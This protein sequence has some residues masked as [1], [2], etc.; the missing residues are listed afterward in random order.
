MIVADGIEIYLKPAGDEGDYLKFP[1]LELPPNNN[2]EG[3]SKN[4]FIPYSDKP[5]QIV[6]KYPDNFD[7]PSASAVH[8]GCIGMDASNWRNY[9]KEREHEPVF[10]VNS[11]VS[12]TLRSYSVNS[13]VGTL[14]MRTIN[15][16]ELALGR[17]PRILNKILI[18]NS[19]TPR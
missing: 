3:H 16:K 11:C 4:C 17:S 18:P 12:G 15:E 7:M 8:V 13:L 1:E 6:V 10:W 19:Q 14:R 2:D 5:F 9:P